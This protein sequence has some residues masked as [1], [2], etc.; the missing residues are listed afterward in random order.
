LYRILYIFI[1]GASFHTSTIMFMWRN[2]VVMRCNGTINIVSFFLLIYSA[3]HYVCDS[4]VVN[5]KVSTLT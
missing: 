2:E 3:R 5:F 1:I 4:S